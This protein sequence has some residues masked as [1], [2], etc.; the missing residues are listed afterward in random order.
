MMEFS[1]LSLLPTESLYCSTTPGFLP[2]ETHQTKPSIF[3]RLNPWAV[4]QAPYGAKSRELLLWGLTLGIMADFL[5]LLP[6]H[7]AVALW[8]HPTFT[9]PD[10]RFIVS[11]LT[12]SIRRRNALKV[13][14]AR[15][16][17]QTAADDTTLALSVEDE[18][19]QNLNA[20]TQ[21][22]TTVSG[23]EHATAIL[24]QGYYDR[25]RLSLGVFAVW[26]LGL[27]SVGS[28]YIWKML[29]RP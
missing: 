17:S 9:A 6:P 22:G 12:Y 10:L 3:Q 20:D 7:N 14:A 5:D 19:G 21:D 4:R 26:R 8:K 11:L 16:P 13:K 15:R 1:A 24:L 2:D 25:L 29:R 23:H 27:A 28:Y 18:T